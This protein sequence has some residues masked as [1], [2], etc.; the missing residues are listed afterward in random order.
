MWQVRGPYA[1]SLGGPSSPPAA[2]H[3]AVL[4]VH[5][6]NAHDK[7]RAGPGVRVRCPAAT[8]VDS[9]GPDRQLAFLPVPGAVSLDSRWVHRAEADDSG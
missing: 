8:D 3:P 4:R 6:G 7:Q 9:S 2:Q 1:S 5:I